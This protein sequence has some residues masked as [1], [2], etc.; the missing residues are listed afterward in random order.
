MALTIAQISNAMKDYYSPLR[1]AQQFLQSKAFSVMPK[2]TRYDGLKYIHPVESALGSGYSGDASV[3]YASNSGASPSF[4]RWEIDPVEA[5]NGRVISGGL[6]DRTR[7]SQGSF[8]GSG[9]KVT[10]DD[11]WKEFISATGAYMW[12]DGTGKLGTVASVSGNNLYLT[13]PSDA[14]KFR[15]RQVVQAFTPGN[16]AVESGTVTLATVDPNTGLLTTTG[17]SWAAGISTIAA[18][19]GLVQQGTYLS[20]FQGIPSWIPTPEARAAGVLSTTYNNV[21]RSANPV[22]LAGV[23]YE[24]N[25]D[26]KVTTIERLAV[27]IQQVGGEA[28][29]HC[30]LSFDDYADVLEYLGTRAQIVTESAYR[31]PQISFPALELATAIGTVKV[32]PDQFVPPDYT[33]ILNINDWEFFSA[34]EYPYTRMYDGLVLRALEN[35]DNYGYRIKG[36]GNTYCRRPFSNGCARFS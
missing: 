12:G 8:I 30:F 19:M 20:V 32:I 26:P 13:N 25:G 14:L 3:A 23:S 9:L 27:K 11:T 34:G 6:M 10:T 36:N 5:F 21:V 31:K 22:I 7:T 4:A 28:P 24:G 1:V 18:G 16:P 35:S 15:I 29:T 33:W 2:N 17:A